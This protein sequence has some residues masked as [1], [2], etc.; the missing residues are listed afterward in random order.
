MLLNGLFIA[1]LT[2]QGP[3]LVSAQDS[4]TEKV[5]GVFAFTVHGENKPSA[6]ASSQTLTDNGANDLVAAG[7]AFRSRYVSTAGGSGTGIQNISPIILDPND[8]DVL[9]TTDQSIVGSAQAFMQGLYPP[10]GSMDISSTQGANGSTVQ[11]SLSGYQY[12]RIVT[13]GKAD[14]QSLLVTGQTGCNMYDAAEAEYRES[15]EV[16]D[17]TRDTETFYEKLRS[18]ALSRVYDES[19]VTYTNA[20][21][22]S[23][24][25]DYELVHNASLLETLN[26]ADVRRA[27]LLADQYMWSTNSQESSSGGS[28]IKAARPIAGQT[29]AT[30]ILE[31][32]DLNVQESGDRQK[33][34][35][36]FGSDEPLVALS[37]LTGLA[38]QS[39][40]NFFSRLVRGGSFVFELYSFED[41]NNMF[42]SYPGIDSLF[43]RFMLHNGTD[44]STNFEA[45]SLFAH[46]PSHASIPYTEFRS[47]LETFAVTT[48]QEWC[49][50][51]NSDAVFCNGVMEQSALEPTTKKD[52]SPA[53]AGV[54]GAI[55]TLVVVGITA[56]I[57]FLL[58][59]VLK[60][61][62][63]KGSLGGFKGSSKHDSD[64]DVS[65]HEP[66]WGASTNNSEPN[67]RPIGAV[68]QGHERTG[69]WEME[70]GKMKRHGT[71]VELPEEMEEDWGVLSGLQPVKIRESV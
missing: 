45:Y 68:V 41:R 58:C 40:P 69:S 11:G 24:Y 2:L 9:S 23:E 32:F 5:W 39:Q 53:V 34:T 71:Q 27:R 26:E 57:G 19:S 70:Q 18:L 56:A 48:A 49:L 61:R 55:V 10:L 14:P 54:I 46:G 3:V 17:I 51:C 43:V 15:E 6:I 16:V 60:R 29:L 62:S 38:S 13:V 64:V 52:V 25:L 30:S 28:T 37:S 1:L 65:F 66:V 12:P 8:V 21:Q 47:E 67:D 44:N 31:A 36:L 22:I 50:R 35:L 4:L 63:H 33:M 20:V 42:P 59:G 7:S